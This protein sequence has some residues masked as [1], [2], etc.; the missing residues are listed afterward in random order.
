MKATATELARDTSHILN[1]VQA[2]RKV[3]LVK[4]GKSFAKI[5]PIR[6]MSGKKLIAALDK[7]SRKDQESLKSAIEHGLKHVKG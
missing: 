2:G 5:T 4:H 1:S 7:F 6:P 3:Q